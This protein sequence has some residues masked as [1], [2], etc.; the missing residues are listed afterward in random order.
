MHKMTMIGLLASALVL[1]ATPAALSKVSPKEENDARIVIKFSKNIANLNQDEVVAYQNDAIT[2]IKAN[3]APSLEVVNRY[4]KVLNGVVCNVPSSKVNAIRNLEFV[5]KLD[6]DTMHNIEEKDGGI[7]IRF[8]DEASEIDSNISAQTM[9]VPSNTNKGEG[10]LIGILDSGFLLNHFDSKTNKTYTHETFTALDDAIKVKYSAASEI[11]TVM[12]NKSFHGV[13]PA[14]KSLYFNSK[15]AYYYDYGG[16]VH[17]RDDYGEKI[18]PDNDVFSPLSDHGLHVAS[19]AAGN[20]PT[21]KGIASN[22]QLALFK[23][24]TEYYPN[25]EEKKLYNESSGCF[26]SAVLSALEDAALLGC[27]VL[28]MSFGSDLNDF[29]EDSIVQNTLKRLQKDGIWSNFSAGNSG[30]GYYNGTAYGGWTTDMVDTG[31]LSK[32]SNNEGVMTIAANQADKQ[33]YS[34]AIL[35]NGNYISY[36]DQVVSNSSTTYEVDRHLADVIQAGA[37]KEWVKVPNFG[38]VADYEGLNVR[39]KIA[40]VDRGSNTFAE[41]VSN[42]ASKGASACAIINNSSETV[43]MSFGEDA[44]GKPVTPKIPVVLIAYEDKDKFEGS[45]VLSLIENVYVDNLTARQ[46]ATFSSDGAT[47]DYRIKPEITAPGHLVKGAVCETEAGEIDPSCTNSYDYWSGTSMSAPNYTGAVALLLG[48]HTKLENN[49]LVIDADYIKSVNARTMST[50]DQMNDKNGLDASVRIQGAGMVNVGAALNSEVYLEQSANSGKAKIELGNGADISKGTLKLSFVANNA[51][52]AKTFNAKVKIYRPSIYRYERHENSKEDESLNNIELQ[53][54][55]NTLIKEV[56]VSVNIPKGQNTINLD[57]I[58]LDALTKAYLDEHFDYACP[59]E[60]YIVLTNAKDV[61]LSIPFLGYYG[62]VSAAPAFEPFNFEKEPGKVYPSATVN[63]I[64]DI[65]G[66]DKGDFSSEIV[67]GYFNAEFFKEEHSDDYESPLI[68]W[69]YNK[70]PITGIK[71]SNGSTMNPINANKGKDGKYTLYT[72]NNRQMNT[73]IIQQFIMRSVA[74]NVL[75]ITKKSNNEVV[76]T[77]HM[78]DTLWGDEDKYYLGKSFCLD[79]YLSSGITGHRA[80]TILGLFSD[81]DLDKKYPD[82]EYSLDIDYTLTDGS[83]QKLS[84]NLVITNESTTISGVFDNGNYF[85]VR[86]DDSALNSVT[87]AG[88]TI[89]NPSRDDIGYYVDIS[90]DD[91]NIKNGRLF[92][93][94]KNNV[95]LSTNGIFHIDD[96]DGIFLA[97]GSLTTSHNFTVTKS[98]V[99]GVVNYELAF[100]KNSKA[101]TLNGNIFVTINVP[102]GYSAKNIEVYDYDKNDSAVKVDFVDYGTAIKFQTNHGKFDI[103]LG[104]AVTLSDISVS[105]SEKT[106]FATGSELDL[107]GM[108]VKANYSDGSSREIFDYE[109]GAVDMSAAGKKTVNISYGGKSASFDIDVVDKAVSSVKITALPYKTVYEIGETEISLDGLEVTAY[110]N[111]GSE[112]ILKT[113]FTAALEGSTATAG[114]KSVKISGNGVE[115][116]YTITVLAA[117]VTKLEIVSNGKDEYKVGEAFDASKLVVKATYSDGTSATITDFRVMNFDSSKTGVYSLMIG[118]AGKTATTSITIIEDSVTPVDPGNDSSSVPADSSSSEPTSSSAPS[119]SSEDKPAPSNKGCGGE[120]VTAS[121][122]VGALALV[123]LFAISAKKKFDKQLIYLSDMR[124]C[125][126]HRLLLCLFIKKCLLMNKQLHYSTFLAILSNR[127]S[128]LVLD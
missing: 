120:I 125:F 108:V 113:G 21:Y 103:H 40:V 90:K 121:V 87:L 39:G 77:D 80:Y 56:D 6:Y 106:I 67:G 119:S 18:V 23:V 7:T 62:D 54:I 42:A 101:T 47:F 22:A 9:N 55:T 96:E 110:Y 4:T 115:A 34:Q 72:A 35:V 112:A 20:G 76:L 89:L 84:Y 127:N 69:L 75:T 118:Y 33:Y 109:V 12:A 93:T 28:N 107:S 45:G 59:I 16:E 70:A 83:H 63:G 81:K 78:F 111:D 13:A 31:I 5:S 116:S 36:T 88:K 94:S 91:S 51:G 104:E 79:D 126:M 105:P 2:A 49:K 29:N 10:V 17:S 122:L 38:E 8:K 15:V 14:G 124:R 53:A 97:N 100:L 99:D 85:R 66:F 92:I 27:N 128:D 44:D 95:N 37:E 48:E 57:P 60:G 82:G 65:M 52:E 68:D 73:L 117:K 11:D 123:G 43:R 32:D 86:F 71:G 25:D 19:M 61:R 58:E 114:A 50:A 30:K 98:S 46:M 74:T 1:S 26:D 102:A 24:F 64:M 41:K 3:L